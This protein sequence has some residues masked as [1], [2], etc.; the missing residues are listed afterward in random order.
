MG[1]LRRTC[2]RQGRTAGL[3]AAARGP[4]A[5]PTMLRLCKL[6]VSGT[7]RPLA[8]GRLCQERLRGSPCSLASPC[9]MLESSAGLG[10]V[11]PVVVGA[12]EGAG[13]SFGCL[14]FTPCDAQKN[15]RRV[16]GAWGW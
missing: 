3:T 2:R 16:S 9:P 15:R 7:E 4:T 5:A 8:T 6:H 13:S 12:T 10:V 1:V 14:V 11:L